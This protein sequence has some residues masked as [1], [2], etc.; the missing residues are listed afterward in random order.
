MHDD[1]IKITLWISLGVVYFS[2]ITDDNFFP[3]VLIGLQILAAAFTCRIF[4]HAARHGN[5]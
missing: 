5:I 4:D 2:I 3:L 1:D